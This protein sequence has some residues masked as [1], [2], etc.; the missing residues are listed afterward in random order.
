MAEAF[1]PTATPELDACGLRRRDGRLSSAAVGEDRANDPS[2]TLFKVALC[3]RRQDPIELDGYGAEIGATRVLADLPV[4]VRINGSVPK[5][6]EGLYAHRL[7]CLLP[8]RGWS[9]LPQPR[10]PLECQPPIP[11]LASV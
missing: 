10:D 8:G 9:G 6:N 7:R 5:F 11:A 3:A 4:D 1:Q 2:R